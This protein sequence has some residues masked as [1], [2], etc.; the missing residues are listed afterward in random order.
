MLLGTV[1]WHSERNYPLTTPSLPEF[2]VLNEF[3]NAICINR[4]KMDWMIA[5]AFP[6]RMRP[7][8]EGRVVGQ[9]LSFFPHHTPFIIKPHWYVERLVPLLRLSPHYL[10]QERSAQPSVF[11]IFG[12][13]GCIFRNSLLNGAAF[14]NG[15]RRASVLN[16]C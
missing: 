7:Y 4:H 2:F 16:I 14:D 13:H 11:I 1:L 3:M 9:V 6:K 8:S 10:I 5:L 12:S 15:C